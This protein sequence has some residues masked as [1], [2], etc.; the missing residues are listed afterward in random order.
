[1]AGKVSRDQLAKMDLEGLILDQKFL[2]FLSTIRNSA[3]IE[4]TAYGSEERH[5]HFMEGRRSLWCDI[6]RT[7]EQ[8]APDAILRILTEEMNAL[9]ETNNGRRTYD[10]LKLDDADGEHSADRPVAAERG[11]LLDYGQPAGK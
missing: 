9:K 4:Q 3:G 2:R 11:E 8:I 1:M 5:L 10:R 6:L 7:V